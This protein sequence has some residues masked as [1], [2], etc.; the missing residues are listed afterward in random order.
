[1]EED[2]LKTAFRTRY[3][4]HEFLVMPF[5]LHNAR[6]IFMDLMNRDCKPYIDKFVIVFI[7]DILIYSRT[8]EE[9]GKHFQMTLE[10]LRKDSLYAK[11]SKCDFLLEMYTF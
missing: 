11:L 2:I 7:D 1:M 9:H 6:T 5:E 4:H 8:K 10:L 3:G